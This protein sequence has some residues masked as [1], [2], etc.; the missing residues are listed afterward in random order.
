MLPARSGQR[1][2]LAKEIPSRERERERERERDF[3][4]EIRQRFRR[5]IIQ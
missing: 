2:F 1:D 5:E 3:S 4:G